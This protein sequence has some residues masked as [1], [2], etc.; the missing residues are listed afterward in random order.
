MSHEAVSPNASAVEKSTGETSPRDARLDRHLRE[1]LEA[2]P[3][4][5]ERLVRRALEGEA[6]RPVSGG[7]ALPAGA[8]AAAVLLVALI[9]GFLWLGRAD[10]PTE[11][12]DVARMAPPTEPAPLL[13]ISNRGDLIEVVTAVGTKTVFYPGDTP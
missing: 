11:G 1:A 12:I 5:A 2:P 3:G 6:P 10:A 7:W 8:L 4:R 13:T 9:S